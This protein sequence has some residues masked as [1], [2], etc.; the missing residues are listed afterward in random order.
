MKRESASDFYFKIGIIVISNLFLFNLSAQECIPWSPDFTNRS[1]LEVGNID[2]KAANI[3]DFSRRKENKLVHHIANKIHIKTKASTISD[4]LLF[5]TGEKFDFDKILETERNLRKRRYIKSVRIIPTE[6]CGKKVN[7]RVKTKDNWTFTPGVTF[8][9]SGG[10]NRSGFG[11]QEHNLFGYGKSLSLSFKRNEKRSS[12]LFYYKDPQLFGSRKALS[13][14]L[15]DNTDGKGHELSL[16]LPFYEKD[17]KIAW[18]ISTSKLQQDVSYYNGGDVVDKITEESQLHSAYYGWSHEITAE[19]TSR[20]KVGWTFK[21]TNYLESSK[22]QLLLPSRLRESFPW[23]EVKNQTEK[24]ITKTN[25]RTMGRVEDIFL[26][27]SLTLGAG[28]LHK[29]FGSNNNHLKLSM[30]YSKGYELGRESLAFFKAK[31]EAYLG[32]GRRQGTT[33]SLRAE[34]DH[35]NG[36]GNDFLIV[37]TLKASDNLEFNDQ[38]LLGGDSGLRGYPIAYQ[39]GNKS[40]L[41]Q[42]EKRLYFKKYPLHIMKFG[43]V[44]FSDIGTTWGNGNDPKLLADVGIGLRLVPTRSSTGKVVHFNLSVPLV[45]RGKVDKLQFSIKTSQFF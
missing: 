40:A 4:Q 32:Q 42:A 37:G 28:L 21:E 20:F 18:G 45:D 10:E 34:Y 11:V 14:S 38:V 43:A 27:R 22:Q 1:G 33:I 31:S 12:K 29:S 9:R 5:A 35:F 30:N 25:F 7:I 3:F 44:L 41:I 26:G 24:Y 15:Q 23:L 13:V 17:S 8:S 39:A 36:Q 16:A 6:V 2:V 19:S